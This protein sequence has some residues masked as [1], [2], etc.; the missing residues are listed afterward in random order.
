MCIYIYIYS[1]RQLL[2]CVCVCALPGA[3]RG[4]RVWAGGFTFGM[5]FHIWGFTFGIKSVGQFFAKVGVTMAL[6]WRKSW[7][8]HGVTMVLPLGGP[9]CGQAVSHLGCGFTFG[10]SHLGFHI[11]DQICWA[12]LRKSWRYHGVTMA[13]KLAL[14]C[15]VT[16]LT[17]LF[18]TRVV[19]SL[20]G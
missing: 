12:V 3:A 6:P 17:R 13:Q 18:V 4:P 15:G 9:V 2:V 19:T 16:T 11:W 14:P 20:L 5:R 8:Y 10:V 1:Y 7:R